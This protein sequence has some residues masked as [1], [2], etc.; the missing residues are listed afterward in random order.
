MLADAQVAVLL[1]EAALR[2]RVPETN[3]PIVELDGDGAAIAAQPSHNPQVGVQPANLA[4]VIY[5]SGSTGRPK[6]VEVTHSAIQ[7]LVIRPNYVE[8][9]KASRLLQFAPVSF[10]AATF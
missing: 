7:R 9:S 2:G 4:Y 3:A 5:T 8:L 1:T 10:D 6:G